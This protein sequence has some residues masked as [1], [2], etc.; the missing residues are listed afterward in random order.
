[1]Y[2]QREMRLPG[3]R[4]AL[5]A[6]LCMSAAV[7]VAASLMAVLKLSL[8]SQIVALVLVAAGVGGV[9]AVVPVRVSPS[10]ASLLQH[11]GLR[12]LA[13]VLAVLALGHTLRQAVFVANPQIHA[14]SALPSDSTSH[15]CLAAYVRGAEINRDGLAPLYDTA[16]YEKSTTVASSIEGM[17]DYLGDPFVYPPQ[18]LLLP[19][20]GIALTDNLTTIRI[21][22]WGLSAL[23]FGAVALL[24]ARGMSEESRAIAWM[25]VPLVWISLPVAYNMEYGQVQLLSIATAMA[26]MLAFRRNHDALGGAL[27]AVAIGWKIFPGILFVYLLAQERW[28]AIA[29]TLVWSLVLAIAGILVVGPS[30]F[31]EF[32]FEH[33]PRLLSGEAFDRFY[34]WQDVTTQFSL[35]GHSHVFGLGLATSRV[36]GAVYTLGIVV[37]AFLLGRSRT[38]DTPLVWLAILNLAAMQSPFAPASYLA[39]SVVWLL[40]LW[41]AEHWG[42]TRMLV[43]GGLAWLCIQTAPFLD[44]IPGLWSLTAVHQVWALLATLVAIVVC[45][46]S[47]VAASFARRYKT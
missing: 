46:H 42:S 37:L 6:P 1:M 44:G 26:A 41:V 47:G 11:R 33:L 9:C 17:A 43:L 21:V 16:A 3:V 31:S 34:S 39:A 22:W 20:L 24:V 12:L 25:L 45:V 29:S 19:R 35:A 4:W 5:C 15:L 7:L 2:D 23:L 36:V 38:R 28:R 27:L 14:A 40:S 18:A 8:T 13:I 30:A 10:I 32:F